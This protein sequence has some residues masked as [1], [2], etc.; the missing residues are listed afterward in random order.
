MNK[1]FKLIF[2]SN[3]DLFFNQDVTVLLNKNSLFYFIKILKFGFDK[4]N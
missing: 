2:L 1:F 4:H 3:W